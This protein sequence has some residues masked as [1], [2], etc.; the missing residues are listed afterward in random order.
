MEDRSVLALDSK[1]SSTYPVKYGIHSSV[2]REN[3]TKGTIKTNKNNNLVSD[4][5][6]ITYGREVVR[7]VNRPSTHRVANNS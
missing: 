3:L 7:R 6:K 1:V 2:S 4:A 5:P